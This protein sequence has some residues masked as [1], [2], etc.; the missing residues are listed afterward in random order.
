MADKQINKKEIVA[1]KTV[2]SEKWPQ[3]STPREGLI[4]DSHHGILAAFNEMRNKGAKSDD[5]FLEFQLFYNEHKSLFSQELKI[6]IWDTA[7]SIASSFAKKNKS[8]L[9]LLAKLRILL[10]T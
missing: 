10:Q 5:C 2:I 6:L 8:E 7:Q 1:L 9:V 4:I 3:L